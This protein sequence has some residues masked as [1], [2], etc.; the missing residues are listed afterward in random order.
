MQMADAQGEFFEETEFD[1]TSGS[2]AEPRS[3]LAAPAEVHSAE[4]FQS[5]VYVWYSG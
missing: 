2:E 5:R 1:K 4:G 3:E